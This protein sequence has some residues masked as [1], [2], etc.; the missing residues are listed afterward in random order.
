MTTSMN[1]DNFGRRN[2]VSSVDQYMDAAIRTASPARLR[3][4]VLERSVEVAKLLADLWRKKEQ[5][6][7]NQY[8]LKLLD[9]I[10]ELLSGVVGG[11]NETEN[12]VC[13]KVSDLY[14]FLSKHLLAAEENSDADAIDEIRTVLEV[15]TE[16]WRAV[17]AQEAPAQSM[18]NE[19]SAE[20]PQGLNLQG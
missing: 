20:M 14:I 18:T 16:T 3:L 8:S 9:L 4:M 12:E 15:E 10:N 11:S 19:S 7:S 6:G 2:S 17:C 5:L 13:H 1:P